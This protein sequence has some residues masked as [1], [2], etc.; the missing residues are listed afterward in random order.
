MSAPHFF[1][2]H[3][4]GSVPTYM[5]LFVAGMV[6]LVLGAVSPW[7]VSAE[8]TT[9]RNAPEQIAV[10]GQSTTGCPEKPSR[11]KEPVVGNWL[12]LTDSAIQPTK[13]F[14]LKTEVISDNPAEK[15]YFKD[16]PL[17]PGRIVKA[18]VSK[19]SVGT[20]ARS[21]YDIAL[22][23]TRYRFIEWGAWEFALVTLTSSGK[24]QDTELAYSESEVIPSEAYLVSTESRDAYSPGTL[25]IL[26]AG[27]FNGDGAL[28]LLLQY[29]SKE[30][31]GLVL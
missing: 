22:G 25:D 27:D 18:K 16:I 11:R 17:R 28:D 14:V 4:Q 20:S 1:I 13:L 10:R 24:A 21:E 15:Y 12:A 31:G 8:I 23:S 2:A 19:R 30:A 29:W 9:G 6:A 3:H 5:R 26:M 7:S